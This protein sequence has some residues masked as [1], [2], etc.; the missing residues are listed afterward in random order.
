MLYIL[1]PYRE[2]GLGCLLTSSWLTFD[3]Y[4]IQSTH[5]SFRLLQFGCLN[6]S[7]SRKNKKK[8]PEASVELF[9]KISLFV[10]SYKSICELLK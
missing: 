5:C 6:Y 4:K 7:N 8:I 10:E 1:S 3:T 2:K 9:N